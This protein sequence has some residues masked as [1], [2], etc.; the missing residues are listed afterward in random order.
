MMFSVSMIPAQVWMLL[1]LGVVL[2]LGSALVGK[3]LRSKFESKTLLNKSEQRLYR[4]VEGIV[5]SDCRVM[6]QVSYGEILRCKNRR[7]FFS[8][9][10]KRADLVISDPHFNV[11]AVIEYQGQG[12][13]GPTVKS[14]RNACDRDRQKRRALA[15]AGVPLIEIPPKFDQELV[16]DALCPALTSTDSPDGERRAA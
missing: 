10:A 5:P 4:M 2:S 9:N 7:K 12:H 8:I 16:R 6:A 15:E 13:Y 14:R 3:L 11:L 1:A